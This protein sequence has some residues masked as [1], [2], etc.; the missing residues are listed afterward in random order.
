MMFDPTKPLLRDN[1][2]TTLRGSAD[3]FSLSFRGYG[4]DVSNPYSVGS[5]ANDTFANTPVL[6]FSRIAESAPSIWDQILGKDGKAGYANT[7]MNVVGGLGNMW[8]GYQ[9]LKNSRDALNFQKDQW[10]FNKKGQTAM[11]N[12][13]LADRQAGRLAASPTAGFASVADYMKQYGV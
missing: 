12:S 8:L 11:H 5:M 9:G 13:A 7:A 10:N 2:Q 3:P 1:S 4:T 6:D